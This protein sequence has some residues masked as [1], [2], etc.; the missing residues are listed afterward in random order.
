MA[1]KKIDIKINTIIKDS[2][3]DNSIAGI[4]KSIKA[5][6]SEALSVGEAGAGFQELQKAANDLQD[7][8]DDLGDSA[9]TLKGTGVEKLTSSFNLLKESFASGDIDKAKTAFKGLGSVIRTS[10]SAIPIFLL[11]EGIKLLIENFDKVLDF[12]KNLGSSA[13]ESEIKIKKLNKTLEET[14]TLNKTLIPELQNR[15]KILEAEGASSEKLLKAKNDLFNAQKKELQLQVKINIE[16]AKAILQTYDLQEQYLIQSANVAKALGQ[17]K[18]A[19]LYRKAAE[20]SRKKRA[21]E[22]IQ[23]A[24]EGIQAIKD[25][26]TEAKVEQ[27]KFNKEEV[28][29]VKDTAKEK[30][31]LRDQELLE[32]IKFN[33]DI[34]DADEEQAEKELAILNKLEA[35]KKEII[36]AANAKAL[37][38]SA[39]AYQE[40]EKLRNAKA[41]K[42]AQ[43]ALIGDEDNLQKQKDLLEAQR[44]EEIRIAQQTGEDIEAINKKY[45]IL[46]EKLSEDSFKKKVAKLNQYVQAAASTLNSI[47]NVFS[48]YQKLQRQN[49]EQDTKERQAKLD[50]DLSALNDAKEQ[51]LAKVG[52]TEEQKA[53]INAKF[54]EQEYQLK[55]DEYNRS[56]DIKKRAFEQDKKLKIAQTIIATIS[57]SV[58][59]LTSALAS[60]QYPAGLILGL[61]TATAVTAAGA[62]QVAAIQRQKFD[63]GTPPQP[64]KANIPSTN[65][66]GL[67]QTN[68]P[69]LKKIGR[70]DPNI[71]GVVNANS[72][73]QKVYVTSSDVDNAIN[74]DNVI[75]RR[76]SF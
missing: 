22:A 23:A 35:D 2:G 43:N 53:A 68:Q 49:E 5:L 13:S 42:A 14:K 36:D 16:K 60:L 1:D 63:A 20:E 70:T 44:R 74:K 52:L 29:N 18:E 4:R 27:I 6:K 40:Q 61:I 3:G 10:F 17:E 33:T 62:I 12:V 30:K 19:E 67:N 7:K 69:E 39:L 73:V 21:E 34:Q 41:I 75:K 66:G 32:K 37:N 9:K 8:L 51:E 38:D 55:L 65:V 72:N 64:P 25:I 71:D 76:S 46:E 15:I 58:A 45:A 31:E 26:N 54:A 24:K 48:E 11:I 28:K 50:A 47:M 59:A 56:T 57:G